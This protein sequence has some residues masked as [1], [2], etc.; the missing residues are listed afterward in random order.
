[1]HFV[2]SE[3]A[4]QMLK[5]KGFDNVFFL[6]DYLNKY[7]IEN[8]L[9]S[10]NTPKDNIV[11]YNPKKG[12]NFT[13]SIISHAK[14]I[15]FVPIENMKREDVAKLLSKAKVYID[16]GNHPG[17]DRL[18]REAAISGC[19]VITGKDGSAKYY[20]DVPIPDEFKIEAKI[21]NIQSIVDKIRQCFENY[22]INSKK[23]ESYRE[24]IKNEE[25]RFIDDAKKIFRANI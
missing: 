15:N 14:D 10:L 11:L 6:S 9:L 25:K 23:F 13:K 5:S 1:M 3:Y 4:R 18:P 19:C 12:L 21:E 8:Q 2:Q 17:K 20:E 24:K 7:F 22:E 16:F